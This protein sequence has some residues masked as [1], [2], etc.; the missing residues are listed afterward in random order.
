MSLLC[1]VCGSTFS[2]TVY[3]SP[4]DRSITTMNQLVDG[5]TRVYFCQN[6]GHLQ[7]NELPNLQEYYANEYEI[8]RSSEDDDQLYKILDGKPLYRS[9]QQAAVLQE[10]VDLFTGCCVLD[11]GCAKAPTL[12]KVVMNNPDIEPFLFDVTDKYLTFWEQFPNQ[13]KYAL[14]QPDNSWKDSMDVV[15]SFYALEHIADLNEAIN[16]IKSLLKVGGV[17]YF[18]VP[19]VYANIADFIVADHIN[20]FSKNSLTWLLSKEGFEDIVVDDQVHDAAFVVTAKLSEKVE[21][22]PVE[23]NKQEIDKCYSLSLEMADYWKEI[24][25]RIL[26]FEKGMGDHSVVAIYGAGFYGHFIASSLSGLEKLC[27]FVD[28]NK[29]LHGLKID[30]KPVLLP[31][32]LPKEVTHLLIGL[33]PRI[34][35][36]SIESID[37]W[38]NR[39]ISFFYL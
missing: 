22:I 7:T 9:D 16:N 3:E 23:V 25:E 28:Q 30:D 12:K 29:F 34:A 17:F 21:L 6:C 24:L 36:E 13:A 11:Y 38:K 4:E 35:R 20:H 31:E 19:N 32:E 10:K 5:K 15:L 8:S 1:N 18:I 33:N 37:Y 14:F 2:S 27:C 39:Q 26:L